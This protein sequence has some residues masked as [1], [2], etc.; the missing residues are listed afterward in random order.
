MSP[1][2]TRCRRRA[3]TLLECIVVVVV[4]ALAVPPT[5]VVDG[6]VER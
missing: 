2:I 4:L 6:A 5:S 3:S 1:R